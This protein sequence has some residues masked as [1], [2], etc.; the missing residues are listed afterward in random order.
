MESWPRGLALVV[1]IHTFVNNTHSER[2]G[3]EKDV[4]RLQSILR[5]LGYFV[6]YKEDLT[7]DVRI[8]KST[9][10][11]ER[12]QRLHFEGH[13]AVTYFFTQFLAYTRYKFYH[14]HF[15]TIEITYIVL[16]SRKK[17]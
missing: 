10:S 17:E 3:S 1:N 4:A 5:Q 15:Y 7:A 11:H 14:K 9:E 8:Y 12:S 2:E 13:C 6:I 16:N